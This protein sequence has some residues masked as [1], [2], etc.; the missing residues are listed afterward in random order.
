LTSDSREEKKKQKH[1]LTRFAVHF[2][3]AVPQFGSLE[4]SQQLQKIESR[5]VRKM[6]TSTRAEYKEILDSDSMS[7]STLEVKCLKVWQRFQA[8]TFVNL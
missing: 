6:H 2:Q 7:E 4:A 3:V 1:I 8:N 5:G